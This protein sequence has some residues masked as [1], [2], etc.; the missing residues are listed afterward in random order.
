MSVTLV[1]ITAGDAEEAREIGGELVMR[2]LAACVNI[3]DKVESMYWW[4]GK[5]ETSSEVVLIAKTSSKKV[6]L[7]IETVTQLHSYECPCVVAIKSKKGNE[8]FFD[9]VKSYTAK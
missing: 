4:D 6:D 9:W 1:Y 2:H 5:L 8:E 7:L 3:F